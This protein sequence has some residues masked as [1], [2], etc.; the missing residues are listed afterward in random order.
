MR[1]NAVKNYFYPVLLG[2]LAERGEVLF[3]SENGV[4]FCIVCGI[5]AVV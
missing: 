1:K 3:V 5:V 4:D 2:R